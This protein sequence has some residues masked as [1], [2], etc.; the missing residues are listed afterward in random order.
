MHIGFDGKRLI[1][2]FTGLG[3]YSRYVV[4]LLRKSF[5][6][7][8]LVIYS[9]VTPAASLPGNL[10]GTV[11]RTP[12]VRAG[13]SLWRSFG[14]IKALKRDNLDL[15]HGLSNEIPFG[16]ASSGIASVVTIHDLIFLKFPSYY[17]YIDRMIYQF[18]VRYAC[19]AANRI[20]AI[21][22]QSKRDITSFLGTP[23]EKIEVV[24]MNCDPIFKKLW[25]PE[26]KS[27][28]TA[29]YGLPA[30]FLLNVGTIEERKN[31]LL[32]VKALPLVDKNVHLVVIG[33]TTPYTELVRQ[34]IRENRLEARVHFLKNVP[35][36]DLPGIY[37]LADIFIYPSRYEGFG[38]PVVEAIQSQVPVIA[39]TGSCLEEAGGPGALYTDPDNFP[40]LAELINLVINNPGKRAEM[41]E[42]GKKHV[43]NFEDDRIAGR[44]MEVYQKAINDVK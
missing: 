24:Y 32:L 36:A 4:G 10:A 11:V 14:I 8:R 30:R 44:I 37:Q 19:K 17:P 15:Y 31:L 12:S 33:K 43:E 16:M 3:N 2:N 1:K 28:L 9:P 34:H 27:S 6:G 26:E 29:K 41:I 13:R 21:S 38:I 20:I 42:M 18:K 39:A 35:F 25:T 23:A 22:E 40:Q 5:P 7:N